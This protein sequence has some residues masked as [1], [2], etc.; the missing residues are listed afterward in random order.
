VTEE[1]MM[2][3]MTQIQRAE[4]L[5]QK[6]AQKAKYVDV[7]TQPSRQVVASIPHAQVRETEGF[8]VTPSVGGG[9][10]TEDLGGT[11]VAGKAQESVIE[12][13]GMVFRNLNGPK[14]DVQ[15]VEPAAPTNGQIDLHGTEEARRRIA[16]SMCPDF[17][18]IYNFTDPL[19]K[20]IARIQA[21]F[22][23]RADII[24]AIFAAETDD[25]KQRILQ[26]FPDC[27]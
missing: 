17:P 24:R 18:D 15:V 3:R 27:F 8:K 5:A 13:E 21:D 25:M 19:R 16:K 10:M 11:G 1:E 23:D 26:E 22:D 4:Y 9:V 7:G 20:K 2:A 14:R 6:D 12:S